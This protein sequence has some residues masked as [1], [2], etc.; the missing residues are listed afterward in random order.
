[1]APQERNETSAFTT[2]DLKAPI[3]NTQAFKTPAFK[4]PRVEANGN[5]AKANGMAP[6]FRHFLG[7]P[8]ASQRFRVYGIDP[9]AAPEKL[10]EIRALMNRLSRRMV[11]ELQWP[12]HGDSSI[13]CWENPSIPSGYTYLL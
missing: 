1:M 3:L 12:A 2:S 4:T 5:A 9:L 7:T 11:A 8:H 10:P 13:A 6:G